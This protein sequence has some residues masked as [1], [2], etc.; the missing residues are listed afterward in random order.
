MAMHVLKK[1]IHTHTPGILK[2][3]R[4]T[5]IGLTFNPLSL[6]FAIEEKKIDCRVIVRLVL[7]TNCCSPDFNF[8]F[9]IVWRQKKP[10]THTQKVRLSSGKDD[11]VYVIV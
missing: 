11:A 8:I 1:K 2:T 5:K 6:V 9:I 4:I 7:V 10:Q 3:L